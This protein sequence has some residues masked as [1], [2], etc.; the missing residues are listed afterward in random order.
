MALSDYR[1]LPDKKFLAIQA[2][3]VGLYPDIDKA[4]IEDKEFYRKIHTGYDLI[5]KPSQTKF[6]RLVK[7]QGGNAYHG[8]KMLL[9][10]GVIA[11]ELWNNLSVS[12]EMVLEVYEVLKEKMEIET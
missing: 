1:S 4:V 9:Y 10:Q 11:Y 7:E 12:E 6:M 8:L 2:T 3:S 5:Y